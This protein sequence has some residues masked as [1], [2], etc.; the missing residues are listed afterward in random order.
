MNFINLTP[1]DIVMND[2]TV[3]PSQGVARL[4]D[5]YT[6]FDDNGVCDVTYGDITNLPDPKYNTCYIVSSLV[7]SAAKALGRKDVVT[8]A[9]GHSDCKRHNGNIVSVPGFIR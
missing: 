7:L 5:T 3:Y 9:T 2:G 1:H 6:T 4:T 8:P